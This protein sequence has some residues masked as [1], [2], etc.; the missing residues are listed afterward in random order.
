MASLYDMLLYIDINSLKLTLTKN[1]FM[2]KGSPTPCVIELKYQNHTCCILSYA[3]IKYLKIYSSLFLSCGYY[4]YSGMLII[5]LGRKQQKP[6]CMKVVI[7]DLTIAM[8][9]N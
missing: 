8:E 2:L 6:K 4:S 3:V 5:Q 9:R 1:N 7:S